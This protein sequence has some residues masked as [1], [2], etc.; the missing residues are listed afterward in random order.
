MNEM[1]ETWKRDGKDVPSGGALLEWIS[2]DV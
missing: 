1:V 2:V